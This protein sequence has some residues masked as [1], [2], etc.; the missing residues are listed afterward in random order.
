M[1]FLPPRAT[2]SLL[3]ALG[4]AAL[5]ASCGDVQPS[6]GTG[7]LEPDGEQSAASAR[8]QRAES[9]RPD[10]PPG[11]SPPGGP[12][13]DARLELTVEG[14]PEGLLAVDL[15]Q[16]GRDELLVLGRTPGRL[17][18]FS[19]LPEGWRLHA[20]RR[21]LP[22]PDYSLGPVSLGTA[23]G[24]TRIAIAS[25]STK[26]L[27]LFELEGV[28]TG[29]LVE[30]LELS[31]APRAVTSG[32]D[33][34]S[35]QKQVLAAT[36]GGTLV[37]WDG[38]SEPLE[39]P[40]IE[41]QASCLLSLSDGS[42]VLIGDQSARSL[43]Y[44]PPGEVVPRVR[45]LRGMPRALLELDLDAS[46]DSEL[47]VAGGDRSVWIFG[48]EDE[49]GLEGWFSSAEPT[50]HVLDR[51]PLRLARGDVSGDGRDELLALFFGQLSYRVLSPSAAD[52]EVA[53]GYAGQA[54][55]DLAAGDFDGDGRP[56]L[57]IANRDARRVGLI[58]GDRSSGLRSA[59][60]I[61][62]GRAPHSICSLKG[63]RASE[64]SLAVIHSLEDSWSTY[65]RTDEGW[66]SSPRLPAGSG[67]NHI[68]ALTL[69]PGTP[70]VLCWSTTTAQGATLVLAHPPGQGGSLPLPPPLHVGRSVSDLLAVDL[71]GDGRM[72]LVAC[73]EEGR[74]LRAVRF[75]WDDA[76]S[77]V[78]GSVTELQL[79]AG[80]TA[81]TSLVREGE[82][83]LAVAC[84][85]GTG[86]SG[87]ALVRADQ[88][89]LRV[90]RYAPSESLPLDLVASDWDADGAQD[91]I[92]LSKP[93][94]MDSGGHVELWRAGEDWRMVTRSATGQ[95]PYA[96]AACDWSGEGNIEVV[97]SAQNSHNVGLW[98]VLPE[99]GA[100]RLER[101]ADLGAGLGPLDLSFE[102]L[103]GDGRLELVVAGA[104]SDDLSILSSRAP[105]R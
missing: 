95:R 33:V 44:Y 89:G 59:E 63:E 14:K 68:R 31:S 57:A 101:Q 76:E 77:R 71:D 3:L 10:S 55:W 104:F 52:G 102:D 37:R 21:D 16:D 66:R 62:T 78:A 97:V 17:S 46:G 87:I 50:E 82:L 91:L 81:V 19:Q 90:E 43:S 56:D 24:A 38:V 7:E 20:L 12:A 6:A 1:D 74:A 15:D 23:D 34:E 29:A 86:G 42:G 88:G 105:V 11:G 35:G 5:H 103:D 8:T 79:P 39:T 32:Q 40:I 22:V 13:L 67:A 51:I 9:A 28:A 54:P 84:A 99:G 53:R 25:R 41:R 98:R 96:L 30:R 47:V 60:R 93:A 85:D 18:C 27:L 72:E 61:P 94:P 75:D 73:D 100:A 45:A 58:Y 69:Q 49:L 2:R 4:V 65:S 26:E 70:E 64:R 83:R 36:A 48:L 92:V 80:P